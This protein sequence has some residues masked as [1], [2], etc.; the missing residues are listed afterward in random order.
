MKPQSISEQTMFNTVR[1]QTKTGS[2]TGFFYNFRVGEKIFPTIITNK[3]VVNYKEDEEVTFHLHLAAEDGDPK[4]NHKVTLNTHWYFHSNKDICFTFINP[5][6]ETVEQNTGKKVFFIANDER[7]IPS[8]TQLE[9]L[10]AL[11]ELVMVGYPIGLWDV[12]NNFPIFRKGFT[13]AHPAIDFNEN[14]I[15][16]VDMTCLPGSSG[17]PIYVLNEGGY[18]DKK[19]NLCWGSN[20]VYFIGIL[21]AGP[22]YS[23]TGD[24]VVKTIP[25]VQ[26]KVE[27]QTKIMANLGY[28]IKTSEL[29]EFKKMIE[30]LVIETV[31][32][33]S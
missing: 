32:D 27:T 16:L 6:I 20:R 13:A 29:G 5:V 1:L 7:L 14:G 33:Q 11:E 31:G 24:I 17:S 3:H 25:T 18:K 26:Q 22:Q 12:K 8:Q 23:A 9:E 10:N 30:K 19:G 28:Y 4:F 15:G 21:F 2:G